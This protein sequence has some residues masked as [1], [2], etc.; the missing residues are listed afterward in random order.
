MNRKFEGKTALIT[1]GNSGIGKAIA[2]AFAREG[3][4]VVIAARRSI[5]GERTAREIIDLGGN[6]QFVKT[7]VSI[8]Q[9]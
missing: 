7:D 9:S 3:C 4:N 2:L 8:F 1:G 6:A 5:E